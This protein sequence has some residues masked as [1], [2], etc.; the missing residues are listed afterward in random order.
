MPLIAD[1]LEAAVPAWAAEERR[2]N[3][4]AVGAILRHADEKGKL[5]APQLR[6]VENYLWLKFE[7]G[8]GKLADLV[9]AGKFA[10]KNLARENNCADSDRA[11]YAPLQ[12]FL[13]AVARE[14]GAPR[15]NK[16]E[17]AVREDMA[18]T[19]F[20]WES[21]LR[22]MLR[23]FSYPNHLY[24]LPMGA[25]K[26]FLMAAFICIDLH[27]SRAMP[28]DRRFARNFIVFA[29]PSSKTA[30]LPSLKTIR[31]F[32]PGWIL[33]PTAA[34]QARREMRVEILDIPSAGKGQTRAKNPNLAKVN[35]L[36]QT[37]A[38]GLV[39]ITNAEKV[40]LERIS[41]KDK[42][43][44]DMRVSDREVVKKS[45][46]LRERMADI[47]RFAVILDEAH[48]TY[49]K[50]NAEK[51]FRMAVGELA[52]KGNLTA[53]L[54]FSGTPFVPMKANIGGETLRLSQLQ[55][56]V[57]DYP[58]ARGIG[59]FL[60]KPNIVKLEGVTEPDFVAESLRTFFAECDKTYAGGVKS[61]IA[62]YCPSIKVLNEKILPAVRDWCQQN[63]PGRADAE[64]LR[65]YSK[66]KEYPLPKDALASFYDLD[67]AHSEHRIVLL[68]AVG[69]EGWDCRSLTAVALPRKTTTKNFV[70]Q[71]SCRCLREVARAAEEN[72]L[73]VLGDGNYGIL[74][75]ELKDTHDTTIEEISRG[76][77]N[78]APVIVRKPGLGELRYK[79][80]YH[81]FFI[82]SESGE[83]I[84]SAAALASFVDGGIARLKQRRAYKAR[85]DESE[86]TGRGNLRHRAAAAAPQIAAR[87]ELAARTYWAFL[88]ELSRAL[89]GRMS[90][91][92]LARNYD[93]PLAAVWGALRAES[94]W[95][96]AHPESESVF[97]E[98]I[99]A[100][101]ACF[102]EERVCRSERI[103]EEMKIELL[104]W[105][106]DKS[107]PWTR[108]DRF[109]PRIRRHDLARLRKRPNRMLEDWED[110]KPDPEDRGFNYLPYRLD[111]EFERA[112]LLAM[113]RDET[114][115][116]FELYYNGMRHSGIE[117][118]RI[119]TP[120]GV[121]TP[122]FLLIKRR[123]E[124]YRW[125]Q[126]DSRDEG[127]GKIARVLIIE[128]KGAVFQDEAEF[129]AKE[130]F[131]RSVFCA[132]NPNFAYARFTEERGGGD[133]G[134]H[135][136]ALA[137]KIR[138]WEN[139]NE[140]E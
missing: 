9:I 128:T 72:A 61:K 132:Q 124:P 54:G 93:A 4:S 76:D 16:L 7:G 26:T 37:D 40:V 86:I 105:S 84:D 33:P 109:I 13:I 140:E 79:N 69:T 55:D 103:T 119:R 60:K 34:E 127:A 139:N 98:A 97:A 29:P 129:R 137:Q 92:D 116:G 113:L 10:D 15:L 44:V 107:I 48:H 23:D 52:K 58:L 28:D 91:A 81:R 78:A 106:D 111:S 17:T 14:D 102:A 47:P 49:G 95:F 117:S 11:Q 123:G 56:I 82:E 112:A 101:A 138:E 41:D 53:M 38:R 104:E 66:D 114:T 83:T 51:K 24:S 32:D 25:G 63:R 67:A 43:L 122:D 85:R 126:G 46:A 120:Y 65:Y 18:M 121:Y 94:E 75:K 30:I 71:S 6:A 62:F 134:P 118:F 130:S 115:R 99:R 135:L 68:V 45:N 96:R 19:K 108:E 90:A 50:E 74:A 136:D 80:V 131:V 64:I 57:Y 133:F 1:L 35:R 21:D 125:Q 73:I 2:N 77:E 39:F 22:K 110:E 42:L 8:N 31:D 3:R 100:V 59:R 20:D 70:L 12:Q 5:R 36:A 87:S 88:V 89:W 27:F